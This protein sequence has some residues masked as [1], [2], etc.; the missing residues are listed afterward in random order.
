VNPLERASRLALRQLDAVGK[1][2]TRPIGVVGRGGP[3]ARPS[4]SGGSLED[5]VRGRSVLITGASSGIGAAAARRIGAAGGNVLAV[6]RSADKLEALAEEIRAGGGS[7]HAYPC[8]LSDYDSIDAMT[9]RVLEECGG[10]DIL[11]N[12]AGRSIRRSVKFSYDR[13]H[14]FERT[15]QLNYLAPVRLILA[16]LPGIRERGHGQ[17]INVSSA[18]VLV[19]VPRFGAYLASKAALDTLSDAIQAEV[20]DEGVH[21]TTIHMSLVRTPMIE[22]T[23]I[24]Q[25]FPALE[26]DEAAGIVCEAII[27]RPRRITPPFGHAASFTDAV[28]P[29]L[30]DLLRSLGYRMFDDSGAARGGIDGARPEGDEEVSPA[31]RAFARATRGQ[32]W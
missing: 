18:G 10:V 8:D 27:R 17:V 32:Y 24:Y 1:L 16:F 3:L 15:M 11:V 28:S 19:R 30:M 4:L 29:R 5:A 7:A 26:P 21:F 22:P 20:R 9:A 12:N 2:A 14:D 23:R 6:A 31:A 25:R 13:F